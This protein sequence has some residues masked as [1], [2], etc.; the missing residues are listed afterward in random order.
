MKKIAL[1]ALVMLIF[2]RVSVAGI[3]D[4]ILKGLGG[5]TRGELKEETII[6]GLKEALDVGTK[7]AV[8]NVSRQDG[9]FG[10]AIIK[11][12]MPEKLRQVSDILC[13][14]GY[15]RQV[16]EFVLSMNR[17]AEKAAPLAAPHFVDAV[18]E[19]SFE[20]ARTILKGGN[21]A[22]TDYFRSKTSDK[23]YQTFRP[24]ISD[25]LD[26]VG[27][28]R[29]YKALLNKYESI[30]FVNKQSFDLDHYVTLKSLDG[31]FHMIGEEEKKIR[32]DPAARVTDLLKTVFSAK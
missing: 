5:S 20:D 27:S 29:K 25:S 14:L 24:I 31:L 11:I 13:K 28:T 18:R 8:E 12:L 30:P 26:E 21:T 7:K 4:D 9:Y 6:A 2:P 32:T 19:M 22:A 15:S 16:D 3:F 1:M 10:N 17:A 23:L